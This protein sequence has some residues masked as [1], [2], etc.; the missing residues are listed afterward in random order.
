ME[1]LANGLIRT[2]KMTVYLQGSLILLFSTYQCVKLC[3]WTKKERLREEV[4]LIRVFFIMQPP[5]FFL[6]F[7]VIAPITLTKL[8]DWW[9]FLFI[10]ASIILFVCFAVYSFRW[11]DKYK[12]EEGR[13]EKKGDQ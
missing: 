1:E 4:S 5:S 3:F 2:L 11:L 8:I 9:S 12:R 6:L 7:A 13:S 10:A